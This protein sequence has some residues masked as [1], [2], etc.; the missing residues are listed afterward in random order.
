[1]LD[2]FNI[3]LYFQD[4]TLCALLHFCDVISSLYTIQFLIHSTF[5]GYLLYITITTT[6]LYVNNSNNTQKAHE[7]KAR[8]P[9]SR[10]ISG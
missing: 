1:V 5:I 2:F 10:L 9:L 6:T 4:D 8:K 7:H 3:T